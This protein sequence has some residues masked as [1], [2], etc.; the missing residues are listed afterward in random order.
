[1]AES[2]RDI[3]RRINSFQNMKQITKA[4]EMVSAA[5]LRR[6][7]EQVESGRPYASKIREVIASVAAGTQGVQHPML[8]SRTVKKT[9]Y[10]V[11]TSDRGLA[12]GF[13]GNLLRTL[14]KTVAD[15]HQS[16]DEYVIFVIG[17]KG[18]EFLKRR[19]YPVIGEVTGLSG[20]PEVQ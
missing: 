2:M 6:A 19:D 14:V 15:R 13:N 7:Q 8:T 1:M 11:I 3:K 10:L 4:F 20:Q 9:G 17:R 5:K 12:G 18:L 16:K